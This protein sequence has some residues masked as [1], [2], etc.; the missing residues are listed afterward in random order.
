[1]RPTNV[2]VTVPEATVNVN[3]GPDFF[4]AD[5]ENG[6]ADSV[7]EEQ[8]DGDGDAK[9]ADA[10]GEADADADGEADDGASLGS[11][12]DDDAEGEDEGD[13]TMTEPTPA[14]SLAVP[15]PAPA[16]APAPAPLLAL[17]GTSKPTPP[18]PTV[19]TP[20]KPAKTFPTPA[21]IPP[22]PAPSGGMPILS[23]TEFRGMSN[24]VLLTASMNG[25]VTLVDRRVG[26]AI[27]RLQPG[28]KAPP[29]C[30][31]VSLELASSLPEALT[32][33]QHGSATATRC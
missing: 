11:L 4:K 6:G 22:K 15:T 31:S 5:R 30:M 10:D 27:G 28:E 8:K 1:M 32:L 2:T 21:V 29:W 23:P 26:G 16:P 20:T 9:M 18:T 25:Q 33:R 17:P 7:K 14:P 13:V 24:D 12:F 19:S 3:V